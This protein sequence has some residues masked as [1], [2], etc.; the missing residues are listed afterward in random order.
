MGGRP[1]A[2]KTGTTDDQLEAWF[3]GYTPE[4]ACSVYVGW[5]NREQSLPGTGGSVAGPIWAHFMAEALREKPHTEWSAPKGVV[6]AEVCDE[7]GLL[8]R[9][10]CPD[11]HY[12][13]FLERA[14]PERERLPHFLGRRDSAYEPPSGASAQTV[15]I[16]AI[17]ET[18]P[19]DRVLEK[20]PPS[21]GEP[22]SPYLPP[23]DFEELLRRLFPNGLRIP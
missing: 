21:T 12:E 16:I 15:P 3:V 8:A 7:T 14:L 1:A 4:L 20:L 17:S 9:W 22:D 18:V 19:P 2:G 11:T 5:D 6:W 13:V 23:V 10:W